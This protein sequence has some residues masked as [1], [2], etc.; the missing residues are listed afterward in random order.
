[1]RYCDHHISN[2]SSANSERNP[3][4]KCLPAKVEERLW[5]SHSGGRPSSKDNSGRH[6]FHRKNAD[7]RLDRMTAPKRERE[8]NHRVR[9]LGDPSLRTRCLQVANVQSSAVK[10]VV[11]ELKAVLG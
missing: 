8:Q 6:L 1:M 7:L 9:L 3:L 10:L 5:S 11:D 2:R 4:D